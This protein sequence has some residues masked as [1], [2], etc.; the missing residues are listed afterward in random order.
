ME[1]SKF[2][3]YTFRVW[4]TAFRNGKTRGFG[5][6]LG[7]VTA[8]GILVAQMATGLIPS[9][10]NTPLRLMA[11]I[12]PHALLF[13]IVCVC[14]VWNAAWEYDKKRLETIQGFEDWKED[15]ARL[16]AAELLLKT[17]RRLAQAINASSV[18]CPLKPGC[19]DTQFK[20][21]YIWFLLLENDSFLP[22]HRD[23]V[24]P[25]PGEQSDLTRAD[26]SR[27]LIIQQ[28]WLAEYSTKRRAELLARSTI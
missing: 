23:A 27:R 3:P 28:N 15:F 11:M 20:A 12:G 13:V 17:S 4:G 10:D 6:L 22:Y 9:H 1:A 16:Q 14:Y 18:D 19:Q 21:H 26:L 8:I 7:L 24:D 2:W 5:M 25:L